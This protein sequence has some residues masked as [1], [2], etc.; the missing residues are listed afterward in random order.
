MQ[1]LKSL[2]K[3]QI[4]AILVILAGIAIIIPTGIKMFSFRGEFD[5]A[6]RNNFAAGNP[7]VDL[8]R[9]WMTVRFISSSYGVP[10]KYLFEAVN[11]QPG[12][13]TSMLAID[14]LNKQKKMGQVNGNP[15]LM[16]SLRQAIIDYRAH[17]VVTGLIEQHVEGWMTIQYVS[18][19]TGIPP[20]VFIKELGLPDEATTQFKPLDLL[21]KEIKYSGGR[22]E[23]TA[24]VEAV[25]KKT[26]PDKLLVPPPAG[27]PT[28]PP[29]EE[30]P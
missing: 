23:F 14:R 21:S 3:V 19:S 17:P 16:A 5:Y 10:Q 4:I 2:T 18:N 15:A 24:A 28:P 9:P 30:A 1:K 11:I 27:G 12:R 6:V 26:A 7:S 29:T 25:V 13:D 8:L 22:P 20:A